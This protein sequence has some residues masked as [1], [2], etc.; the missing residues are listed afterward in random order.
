MRLRVSAI[1]FTLTIGMWFTTPVWADSFF[2]STGSPD[3]RLG[4]L[5]RPASPAGIETETADDFVLQQPTVIT[6]ATITRP[7][8]LGTP[9]DH[10][11]QVEV[12]IYRVFPA[13]SAPFDGKVPTR[14][15]WGSRPSSRSLC[16]ADGAFDQGRVRFEIEEPDIPAA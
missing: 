9:L 10:I 6:G 16:C 11:V 13:D 15:N 3:G 14:L 2:F 12:E 5:S 1:A 8:P 4:A 7:I